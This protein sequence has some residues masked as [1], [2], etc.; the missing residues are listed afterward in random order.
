MFCVTDSYVCQG[1]CLHQCP[2]SDCLLPY[3]VIGSLGH[4]Q[5]LAHPTVLVSQEA[6]EA[7]GFKDLDVFPSLDHL[8]HITVYH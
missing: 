3:P 8:V 2:L 1:L 5:N 4:S 6:T 7:I